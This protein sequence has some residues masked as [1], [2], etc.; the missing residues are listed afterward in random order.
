MNPTLKARRKTRAIKAGGVGIGGDHP[1][2]VQT[3]TNTPTDDIEATAQQVAVCVKAGAELVRITT[4][5]V[6]Q[7]KLLVEIRK[8]AREILKHDVAL[9][10]DV[11]FIPA[12]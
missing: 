10:A 11:H 9:I 2:R 1:I 8:R 3:M 4:Q 5:S 12:A 6:K 7:A